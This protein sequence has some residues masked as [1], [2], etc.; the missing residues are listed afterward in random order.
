LSRRHLL[1]IDLEFKETL[2]KS[3]MMETMNTS[4][5]TPAAKPSTPTATV[6][7]ASGTVMS[8][9]DRLEDSIQ[10]M[11]S[12][13]NR[14]AR[15]ND[16]RMVL[17]SLKDVS[18]LSCLALDNVQPYDGPLSDLE[19]EVSE[20]T[21]ILNGVPF[22]APG[23]T[24]D[25]TA[26][27]TVPHNGNILGMI[28]GLSAQL[29]GREGVKMSPNDLYEKLILRM[30]RTTSSSDAYFRLNSLLGSSDLLV[31]PVSA[32]TQHAGNQ[33]LTPSIAVNKEAAQVTPT[34]TESPIQMNIY[35]S[36][37]EVHMTLSVTYPFGL[38][39]KSDVKPGRPW[40]SIQGL[41][42]ERA[43]FSNDESARN[44]NAKLPDLY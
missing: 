8:K 9:E 10:K 6:A 41:V 15:A 37:G 23:L 17:R 7:S 40:I 27:R 5:A 42:N 43:N 11:R 2:G 25:G 22:K 4:H 38:F 16:R 34:P 35:V 18:F 30:A 3:I 36:N 26:R 29:C 24:S 21:I 20:E 31:M 39:R 44:L 1:P 33:S 13:L 12:N 28:K 19:K 14:Y 32:S